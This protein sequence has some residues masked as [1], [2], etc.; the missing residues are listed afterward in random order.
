MLS[1]DMDTV[2]REYFRW[3]KSGDPSRVGYPSTDPYAPL[4][5]SSVRSLG[6]SD[7]EALWCDA[8]VCRLKVE[9]PDLHQAVVCY[10]RDNRSMRWMQRNGMGDRRAVSR[11]LSEA[12]Q[13]LAEY[14][15][16]GAAPLGS[17]PGR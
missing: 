3:S 17:L 13:L 11:R 10:Y 14:F 15:A 5:G 7:D 6:M 8:V 4:R 1:D 16:E 2:L 12:R 9:A